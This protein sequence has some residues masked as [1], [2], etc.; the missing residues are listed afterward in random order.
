M[1]VRVHVQVFVRSCACVRP[2]RVRMRAYVHNVPVCACT[3]AI[4]CAYM[5]ALG[6][7]STY[8]IIVSSGSELKPGDCSGKGGHICGV[9]CQSFQRSKHLHLGL[10][11]EIDLG[12][13]S[14]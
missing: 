2:A 12:S 6:I 9:Y 5:L 3:L 14:D 4:M 7:N 13:R 8:N 1:G 11:V 10:A